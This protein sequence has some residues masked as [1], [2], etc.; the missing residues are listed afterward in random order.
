MKI[1]ITGGRGGIAYLTASKLSKLGHKIYLCTHTS[2]QLET[3]K[4]KIKKE[5]LNIVPYKLDI[6]NKDDLQLLDK[7]DYDIVWAHAGIGN[8]GTLLAMEVDVLREN[9][10]TNIFGTME[11]V[12]K[13][14]L[15]F[16]Q[17]KKKGKIFVTSSLAGM[18]P[19]PYLS[20]YTSS[21]AALSMLCFTLK[22][23]L[24]ESGTNI[25]IS[26][27]EPGAYKTGFNEVM[28]ENKEKFLKTKNI[29]YNDRK[30]ITQS[31]KKLFNLIENK[32]IDKLVNK[33][34]KEMTKENPKF[35][36]RSPFIQALFTKLYYLFYR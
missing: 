34:I 27:I 30:K 14:Y 25:T 5:Q 18:L 17:Q 9:Y 7:L 11:V 23:E 22:K 29:F 24:K 2:K 8:G 28:I 21:K 19:L 35:K 4:K 26:L 15:N 13:A 16:K 3:L 20:C 31:Q 32:N 6:T 36:I 12:R 33:I 1:L 10:E